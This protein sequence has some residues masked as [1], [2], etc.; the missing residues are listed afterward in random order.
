MYDQ[1]GYDYHHEQNF[2]PFKKI[3]G[4]MY[5]RQGEFLGFNQRESANVTQIVVERTFEKTKVLWLLRGFHE[6]INS[7]RHLFELNSPDLHPFASLSPRKFLKIKNE[8]RENS[9]F[10]LQNQESWSMVLES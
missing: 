1:I 6:A 9:I 2:T 4:Q 5:P 8:K 7:S 3:P 10:F